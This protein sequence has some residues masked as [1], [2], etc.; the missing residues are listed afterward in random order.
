VKILT[1][2]T[3]IEILS[4]SG[5]PVPPEEL[6]RYRQWVTASP[7][8][9]YP[10]L[11]AR[12]EALVAA[13]E[14]A[15]AAYEQALRLHEVADRPFDLARTRLLYGELL[16]RQRRPGQA[17]EH[18]RA[19]NEAFTR[20]GCV[21]WAERA[22]GELRAAGETDGVPQDEAF[23]RLSPQET[24]IVRMVGEGMSNREVAGQLFLSPRTVEYHLYK[25]YPKLG[26]SSRSELVR[27]AATASQ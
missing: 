26:I 1:T 13:P 3:R 12:C 22:R 16:R 6:E 19:A 7:G 14:E 9:S 20:I 24:Q 11:L 23:G 15:A 10:A 5:R 8:P 2:P 18:L 25:A 27:L 4:R 21:L 17:R